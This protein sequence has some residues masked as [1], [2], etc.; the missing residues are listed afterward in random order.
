MPPGIGYGGR[1][2][3]A[4]RS[5]PNEAISRRFRTASTRDEE[6]GTRAE[7]TAQ[8]RL[9]GFDAEDAARRS[10]RAQFDEFSEDLEENIGDLRGSQVGRGRINS[11]FGFEEEDELY[12]GAL[13]D[14]GRTLSQNALQAQ[15][16]NL[17]ATGGLANIGARRTGRAYDILASERDA[18]LLEQEMER[19]RRAEKRG[20]LFGFLGTVAKGGL[21]YLG[22]GPL[23]AA[24]A[25]AT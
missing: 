22:G 19:R 21:G 23:G 14:L 13:E 6:A 12:E 17:Q 10:A 3:K 25:L 11:G 8:E 15:G 1:F 16:L 2:R 24:A 7:D 9:E 20:G 4:L 5:D 18:N